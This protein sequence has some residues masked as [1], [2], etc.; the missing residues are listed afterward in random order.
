MLQVGLRSVFEAEID[1]ESRGHHFEDWAQAL[2][3][4]IGDNMRASGRKGGR[5]RSCPGSNFHNVA[6]GTD[7]GQID[8]F[9]GDVGV[10][11]EVL[12]EPMNRRQPMR[13]EQGC[14]F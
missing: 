1:V 7:F 14:Y 8:N 6:P 12:S 2:I 13:L 11:Q 9:A 5:Q 4:L 10:G 3:H